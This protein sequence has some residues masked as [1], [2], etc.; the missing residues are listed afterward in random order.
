MD[1]LAAH[2]PLPP[3]PCAVHLASQREDSAEKFEAYARRAALLAEAD[4]LKAKIRDSQLAV[5][6]Y[7]GP[8]LRMMVYFDYGP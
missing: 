1:P 5:F 6:R 7:G 8:G 4:D 2:D 3:P